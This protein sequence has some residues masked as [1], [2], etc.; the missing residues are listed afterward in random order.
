MKTRDG[1]LT[2]KI[3]QVPQ[4]LDMKSETVLSLLEEDQLF[5]ARQRAQLGRA[6][7]TRGTRVLMWC[8]RGYVILM[9]I[10]VVVAIVNATHGGGQ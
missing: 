4:D 1:S 8:L 9:L 5:A 2:G 7:L 6:K 3:E 10:V